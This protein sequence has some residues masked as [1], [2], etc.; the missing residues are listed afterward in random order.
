MVPL[1]CSFQG[2]RE[3]LR[4]RHDGRGCSVVAKAG[5]GLEQEEAVT[6]VAVAS[7]RDLAPTVASAAH[8]AGH[9]EAQAA[10]VVAEAESEATEAGRRST[11]ICRL[12]RTHRRWAEG[13]TGRSRCPYA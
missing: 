1:G 12:R 11:P 10:R 4:R 9:A 3:L 5:E 8:R 7:V 2:V 13:D 6:M